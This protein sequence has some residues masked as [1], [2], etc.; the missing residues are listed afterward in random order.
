M[1]VAL[2]LPASNVVMPGPLHSYRPSSPGR[3]HGAFTRYGGVSR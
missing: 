1:K 3:R 2:L